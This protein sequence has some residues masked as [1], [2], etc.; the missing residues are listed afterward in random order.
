M[1]GR[2][3]R[4]TAWYSCS[5]GTAIRRVRCKGHKAGH[6]SSYRCC[7]RNGSRKVWNMVDNLLRRVP[8][9]YENTQ[10]LLGICGCILC[11]GGLDSIHGKFL[12]KGGHIS[13]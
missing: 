10:G 6:K 9:T 8:D 13:R 3:V 7:G 5:E 2:T 1:D 12:G 4:D 11:A